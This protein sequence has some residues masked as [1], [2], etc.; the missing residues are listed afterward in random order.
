MTYFKD[1]TTGIGNFLYI[2]EEGGIERQE[3][4][5]QYVLT[6]NC[7]LPIECDDWEKLESW[8]IIKGAE[9]DPLFVSCVLPEGW[10]KVATG[11][12][13]WSNLVDN[14]GLIRA[15]IFYKGAFYDRSAHTQV[16]TERYCVFKNYNI[17][18]GEA[19]E[20][21]DSAT[22]TTV[23]Q[24][25]T[26]YWGFIVEDQSVLGFGNKAKKVVGSIYNGI[27][28]YKPKGK[29]GAARFS[30]T[31]DV[32]FATQI[33]LNTFYKD[34]HHIEGEYDAINAAKFLLKEEAAIETD[35]MNKESN[36]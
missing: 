22:N 23:Q 17:E 27:F 19:Y 3:A 5:Q 4:H 33:D 29:Y 24:Y 36:W 16:I 26:G 31:C 10:S 34:F 13:M 7:D 1:K 12:S 28:H 25:P 35:R 11:H 2:L 8:G 32:K 21:R 20:I 9:T 15:S 6:N 30:A 14:E 18:E